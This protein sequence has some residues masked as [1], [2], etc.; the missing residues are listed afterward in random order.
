MTRIRVT[1]RVS[2]LALFTHGCVMEP[3][4]L[5]YEVEL[6]QDQDTQAQETESVQDTGNGPEPDF[7]EEPELELTKRE[8]R[9]LGRSIYAQCREA[10]ED[11]DFACKERC[12]REVREFMRKCLRRAK[13]GPWPGEPGSLPKKNEF[14]TSKESLKTTGEGNA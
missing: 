4:Y 11:D 8:C 6:E 3:A 7:P 5:G 12:E 13:K 10:C 14:E 1:L 9:R 2:I